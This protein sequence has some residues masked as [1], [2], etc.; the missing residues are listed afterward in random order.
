M[1]RTQRERRQIELH[2]YLAKETGHLGD[3]GGT[4]IVLPASCVL[5][6]L[7]DHLLV[8]TNAN[9]GR[10]TEAHKTTKGR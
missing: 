10:A 5:I 4:E 1:A 3:A 6:I 7:R 9:S 2:S 8:T